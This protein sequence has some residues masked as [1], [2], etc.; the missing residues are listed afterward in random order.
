MR[1]AIVLT[2]LASA[3]LPFA[4]AKAAIPSWSA[5]K[6]RKHATHIVVG[7]V[8]EVYTSVRTTAHWRTTKYCAEVRIEKIEKGEGL[9]AAGLVYVRYWDREWIGR[10]EMPAGH[11]GHGNQAK[12]GDRMRIYLARNA[13][14][15]AG[16]HNK[17]GGYDVLGPN[18]FEK[19][20]A[21]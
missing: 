12:V 5:E 20:G 21:R 9:D 15:L 4:A 19:L 14:N 16:V 8:T 2:V 18:G 3:M 13:N 11:N 1:N 7:K 17:D 10:G 6:L